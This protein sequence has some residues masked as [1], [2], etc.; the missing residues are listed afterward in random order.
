MTESELARE[1]AK[2]THNWAI[3]YEWETVQPYY[4]KAYLKL[5]HHVHKLIVRGK[6]EELKG[7]YK[8]EESFE[9]SASERISKLEK[10]LKGELKNG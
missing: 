2:I 6:I 4:Q 9:F 1:F 10:E 5:A 7:L 3:P 8:S